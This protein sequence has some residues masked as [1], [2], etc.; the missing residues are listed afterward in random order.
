MC[1]HESFFFK[2]TMLDI[3]MFYFKS[4]KL[5]SEETQGNQKKKID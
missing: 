2:K 1:A 4:W 3:L 5:K